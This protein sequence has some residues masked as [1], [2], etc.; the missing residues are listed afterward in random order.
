MTNEE[1]LPKIDRYTCC[2]ENPVME[3]RY[4]EDLASYSAMH[5]KVFSV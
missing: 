2:F 4:R 1:S 3:T 5:A